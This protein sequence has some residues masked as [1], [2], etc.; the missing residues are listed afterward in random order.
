MC[1][2]LQCLR[3]KYISRYFWE[4]KHLNKFVEL[5]SSENSTAG[6]IICLIICLFGAK[7]FANLGKFKTQML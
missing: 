7:V 5:L 1:K 2:Y 6:K 3:S 4:K